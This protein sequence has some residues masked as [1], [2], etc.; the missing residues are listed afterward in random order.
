MRI[1]MKPDQEIFEAHAWVEFEGEN[2]GGAI[3]EYVAFENLCR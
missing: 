2:L 1:G 3:D